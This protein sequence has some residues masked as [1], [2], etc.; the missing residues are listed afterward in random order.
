MTYF[1]TAVDIDRSA[2]VLELLFMQMALKAL[3]KVMQSL[4]MLAVICGLKGFL[5]SYV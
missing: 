3:L 4:L 2:C 5:A 1:A